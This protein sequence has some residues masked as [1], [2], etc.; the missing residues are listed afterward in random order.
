MTLRFEVFSADLD[1]TADFYTR[2]LGFRLLRDE[3]S[4]DVPYVFLRRDEVHVGALR[5]ERVERPDLRRPPTG[6]ELVLEVDDVVAERDRVLAAG[7]SLQEDLQRRP[8]GLTDFRLLDD[9]G[10]YLR[11]TSRS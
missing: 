4:T 11:V 1:A 10:Y 7:W 5:R 6:V 9:S 2:V 8:W 3:R